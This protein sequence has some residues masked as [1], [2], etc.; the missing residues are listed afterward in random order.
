MNI[1]PVNYQTSDKQNVN[2]GAWII[3][4]KKQ[5]GILALIEKKSHFF[6]L[7]QW[8]KDAAFSDLVF[9]KMDPKNQAFLELS[10][11]QMARGLELRA[12]RDYLA[13]RIERAKVLTKIK[14]RIIFIKEALTAR[15]CKNIANR[16]F[17]PQRD[18]NIIKRF[19]GR[20]RSVLRAF[21]G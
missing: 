12:R 10:E 7:Y 2:F 16:L 21:G 14:C 18:P 13:E 8:R 20:T 4:V 15:R 11:I 6:K 1:S 3:P 5:A 17:G 9:E 19:F